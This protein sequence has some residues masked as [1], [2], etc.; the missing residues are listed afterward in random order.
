MVTREYRV[1]D[2]FNSHTDNRS[3]TVRTWI[4]E[5]LDRFAAKGWRL[6]CVDQGLAY[7]ERETS[8]ELK[9]VSP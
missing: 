8:D 6:V 9:K 2:A 4:A 5:E 1:F 7:L 3:S